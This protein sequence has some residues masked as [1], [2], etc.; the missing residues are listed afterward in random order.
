MRNNKIRSTAQKYRKEN[1][2]QSLLLKI[3]LRQRNVMKKR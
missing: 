2:E 3:T 1:L